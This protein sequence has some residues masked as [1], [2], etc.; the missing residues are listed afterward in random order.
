MLLEGLGPGSLAGYCHVQGLSL[1]SPQTH[2]MTLAKSFNL[3]GLQSVQM[4]K[5]LKKRDA[6]EAQEIQV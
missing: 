4:E 2:C 1:A 5:G 3:L 6:S